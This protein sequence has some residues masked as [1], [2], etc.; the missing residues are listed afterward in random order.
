MDEGL[1]KSMGQ[2]QKKGHVTTV[3][4]DETG[5]RNWHKQGFVKP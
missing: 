3:Y 5:M 1:R 2:A 4:C